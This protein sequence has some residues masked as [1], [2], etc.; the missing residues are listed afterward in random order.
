MRVTKS[1]LRRIIREQLS[2]AQST[3][4]N[5]LTGLMQEFDVPLHSRK[6]V[7]LALLKVYR[8]NGGPLDASYEVEKSMNL[9][10][11]PEEFY[12]QA[13]DL[14]KK[15]SQ[16]R[17]QLDEGFLDILKSLLG[18]FLKDSQGAFN[19]AKVKSN[20][21]LAPL[22]KPE[23]GK[24]TEADK[25]FDPV[26]DPTDQ[27][28]AL[29]GIIETINEAIKYGMEDLKD[30]ARRGEELQV[31]LEDLASGDSK[32]FD[33]D[34]IAG[35]TAMKDLYEKFAQ[36]DY[37][38][39][40]E[41]TAESYGKMAN[42]LKSV[43]FSDEPWYKKVMSIGQSAKPDSTSS[44]TLK[45]MAK[46]V[47]EIERLDI[48]GQA[49]TVLE[50]EPV[51]KMAESDDYKGDSAREQIKRIKT[52]IGRYEIDEL[53]DMIES[54]YEVARELDDKMGEAADVV[55]AAEEGGEAEQQAAVKTSLMANYKPKKS[56]LLRKYI[57]NLISESFNAH[58][59]VNMENKSK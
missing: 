20:V 39:F 14:V 30:L 56:I 42:I 12:T 29:R 36:E 32:K 27:L 11:L 59:I 10:S 17:Q 37:K 7:A 49:N 23:S 6:K 26:E 51:L 50:S 34:K 13:V 33:M 15:E 22:P 16:K 21:K 9:N 19:D 5:G 24:A 8:D 55:A 52:E 48:V 58:R 40:V 44:G 2:D 25:T 4:V 18:D 47:G 46:S 38:K 54:L 57:K 53:K 31:D 43:E 41:L 45:N 3:P 1:E 28:I 35:G